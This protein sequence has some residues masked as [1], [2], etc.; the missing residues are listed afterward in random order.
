MKY[1]IILFTD[2]IV[3]AWRMR[4]LGP[5]RLA[6]ELRNHGYSVKVV[7][8]CVN[9]FSDYPLVKSIIT[10]L[11]GPNTLFVGFSG[12]HFFEPNA[13]P[14]EFARANEYFTW[15]GRKESPYPGKQKRFEL[16]CQLM[17]TINNN[18][19]IAYGGR[20]VGRTKLPRII[21]FVVSGYS[22]TTIVELADHLKNKTPIKFTPGLYPNQKN[23]THDIY[24][25]SFD[26]PNSYTRYQPEDHIRTGEVLYLETSRGCMFKCDFCSY[27]LIG[28][29]STDP[30]YHKEISILAKELKHN[31]DNFKINCY[32][33]VDDTFNESTE[34]L[35]AIY[36]AIK[37]SGVPNFRFGA[38]LRLDLIARHP[39]QIQLLLDMG[40]NGVFFG[41]ES[42]NDKSL[43]SIK[44]SMPAEEIKSFLIE[45]R[46]AWNNRV[47]IQTGL[48]IGLPHDT[49]ET[50][51][52]W[53]K[54][55][56]SSESPV[57]SYV[58]NNLTI[59]HVGN[60]AES[61]S[62]FLSH[63]EKYGYTLYEQRETEKLNIWAKHKKHWKNEHWNEKICAD[64]SS[65][66]MQRAVY[67][68][69]YQP[70]MFDLNGFLNLGY[71][72]DY[73]YNRPS[74]SIPRTETDRLMDQ[75]YN[76]YITELCNYEG[77]PK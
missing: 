7:D 59:Y 63:P 18:I 75:L 66:L 15:G 70:G 13:S 32:T 42:L 51:N 19:K 2:S 26:F 41:I 76:T 39:E 6:T 72:F 35:Q 30:K 43:K 61:E 25:T 3:S 56:E 27:P 16:I 22:D 33:I 11:I 57:N 36:Q 9:I 46:K 65:K 37:E 8:Y 67:S 52:E 64:M 28:R 48:I 1:D 14:A 40:L 60:T 49:P 5:Y 62:S 71:T 50:V 55:F 20:W 74:I 69:R 44:K 17:K 34:K 73:I 38:Y 21:D 29:K 10:E 54:W 45:L 77:I 4:S 47:T 12:T 24:A 58:V 53:M 68:R 31:W 23:I